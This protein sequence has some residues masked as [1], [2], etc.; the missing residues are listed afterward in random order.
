MLNVA[1]HHAVPL[2]LRHLCVRNRAWRACRRSPQAQ[3]GAF[4]EPTPP[5]HRHLKDRPGGHAHS[6]PAGHDAPADADEDDDEDD[7]GAAEGPRRTNNKHVA[8]AFYGLTRSLRYTMPSIRQNVFA[9]LRAAGYTYDVYLH[10]YDL[11]H[12]TNERSGEATA[13]NT[14]EWS[15]LNPDFHEVTSQARARRA[16]PRTTCR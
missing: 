6:T 14:T 11:P 4:H 5:S 12:L 2:T 7:D 16:C 10:T 8:L 13:L 15:L 3:P 1:A 9:P